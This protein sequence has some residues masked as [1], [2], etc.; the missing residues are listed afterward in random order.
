M[1]AVIQAW[2]TWCQRTWRRGEGSDRYGREISKRTWHIVVI[3]GS[4]RHVSVR[5]AWDN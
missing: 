4:K 3:V 5:Y 1:L 2:A